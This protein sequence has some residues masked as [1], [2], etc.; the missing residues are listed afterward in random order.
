MPAPEDLFQYQSIEARTQVVKR[1]SLGKN[2]L[3]DQ[4]AELCTVSVKIEPKLEDLDQTASTERTTSANRT[5]S[6]ELNASTQDT[7]FRRSQ[8]ANMSKGVKR[9]R[10][11]HGSFF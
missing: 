8:D 11:L 5:A 9:R 7:T 4:I 2:K 6:A 10:D 1:P 3:A